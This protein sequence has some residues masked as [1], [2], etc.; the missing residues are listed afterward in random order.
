MAREY[1]EYRRTG[2]I[3]FYYCKRVGVPVRGIV[4]KSTVSEPKDNA[5]LLHGGFDPKTMLDRRGHRLL[6]Q[7][8]VPLR[9]EGLDQFRMQAVLDGNNDGVC[10]TLPDRPDG[11]RRSLVELF[12]GF[13]GET[14]VDTIS[15]CKER[16]GVGPWLRDGYHLAFGRFQGRILC[17]GLKAEFDQGGQKCVVN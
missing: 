11:L 10:E 9:S 4:G 17:I 5:S 12:P 7:N 8:V 15:I 1:G 13:K 16:P 3:Y 2:N 6:A 14:V